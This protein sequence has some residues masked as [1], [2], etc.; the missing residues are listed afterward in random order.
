MSKQ[1]RSF[2]P[3]FKLDAACLG[4]DQ[5]YSISEVAR[6]LDV[7]ITGIRRW[8]RLN[9]AVRPQ[10]VKLSHRSNKK[11]RSSRPELID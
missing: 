11:S 1:R 3:E 5:G 9:E 7:G 2:S 10:P 6:S 4:V 8:V